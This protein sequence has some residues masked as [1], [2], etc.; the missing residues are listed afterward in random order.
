MYYIIILIYL[1]FT[2]SL[3]LSPTT[4]NKD[5]CLRATPF[6]MRVLIRLSTFFRGIFLA[7]IVS[8]GTVFDHVDFDGK[9]RPYYIEIPFISVI[10]GFWKCNWGVYRK[11]GLWRRFY[12]RI[13]AFCSSPTIADGP[14]INF[15]RVSF[16]A[17]FVIVLHK[18]NYVYY[19]HPLSSTGVCL[20]CPERLSD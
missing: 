20:C 5:L 3:P 1:Y 16:E 8:F 18:L 14:C 12:G 11:K 10:F 19:K 2:W 4:T 17:T 13:Q 7:C 9:G 15:W 6:S